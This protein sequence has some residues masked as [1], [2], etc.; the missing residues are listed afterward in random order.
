LDKEKILQ[1]LSIRKLQSVAELTMV[2]DLEKVIWAQ[3]DPVPLHQTATAVKHGGMVIGAFL[4]DRLVGFQY[5]FAGFD[6]KKTYLCS[7]NLGLDP[8]FR[9]LGIGGKLK[10]E[11]RLEAIR[12]GYDLITWTYDPLETMNGNLNIKKLGA[13]CSTY[14]ENCYG[15]M[16]D[17]LNAGVSSDRFQVEWHIASSRVK[18]RLTKSSYDLQFSTD[19]PKLIHVTTNDHGL[20]MPANIDLSLE[21]FDDKL[22]VPVPAAFQKLK[23]LDLSLAID[24]RLK[25]RA[26]FTH[27]FAK[28]WQVADFVKNNG[29]EPV[30]F[31][32]LEKK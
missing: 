22:Y 16:T 18:D 8:E 6:G 27:Y 4:G 5:S 9:S 29:S 24:W 14:L 17:I 23:E 21:S 31:Y 25:T 20:I 11:Q 12:I 7:Q 3:D 15:D 2:R 28:G 32:S 10:L 19:V 13:V 26:V 30:H 1:S